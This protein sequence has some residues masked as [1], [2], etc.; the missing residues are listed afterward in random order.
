MFC[1]PQHM[2]MG[3]TASYSERSREFTAGRKHTEGSSAAS[4]PCPAPGMHTPSLQAPR[5]SL[6]QPLAGLE[7]FVSLHDCF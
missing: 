4:P 1:F 2:Q 3:L 6:L 5:D 7:G